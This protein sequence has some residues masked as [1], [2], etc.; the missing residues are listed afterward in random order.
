MTS[1]TLKNYTR[2]LRDLMEYHHAE[3]DAISADDIL[4]FLAEREKSIGKFILNTL[5]CALKYF[6]GKVLGDPDR[7]VDIP[8]PRKPRDA[9]LI[10][11]LVENE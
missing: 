2:P 6:Y 7:I 1:S 9:A 4:A 8:T 3:A 11:Y 10:T 5:C